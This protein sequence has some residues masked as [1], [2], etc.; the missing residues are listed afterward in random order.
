MNGA[1]PWIKEAGKLWIA[2]WPYDS[3]YTDMRAR[4]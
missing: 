1:E 2:A 4:R 3:M